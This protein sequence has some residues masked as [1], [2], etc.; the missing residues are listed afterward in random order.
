M[1][2]FLNRHKKAPEFNQYYPTI[3]SLNQDQLKYFKW[4]VK[5]LGRDETPDVQG[6]ISESVLC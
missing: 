4:F 6:S 3:E 5:E 2:K 1:F